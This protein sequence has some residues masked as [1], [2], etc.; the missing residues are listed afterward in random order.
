MLL[1]LLVWNALLL[2]PLGACAQTAWHSLPFVK[3]LHPPVHLCCVFCAL[4][5]TALKLASVFQCADF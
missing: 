1:Q 4:L 2:D 5:L 3:I